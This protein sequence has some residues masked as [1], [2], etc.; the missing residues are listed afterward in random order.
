MRRVDLRLRLQRRS[1]RLQHRQ[2]RRGHCQRSCG[3]ARA[4]CLVDRLPSQ[5]QRQVTAV[6][7]HPISGARC[8]NSLREIHLL[9]SCADCPGSPAPALSLKLA[10]SHTCEF[11]SQLRA[12]LLLRA[13]RTSE[14][15]ESEAPK[16]MIC[17]SVSAICILLMKVHTMCCN[18]H[19]ADG[20]HTRF[21][22]GDAFR[23]CFWNALMARSIGADQA[24]EV[25]FLISDYAFS[26]FDMRS[27]R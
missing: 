5:R 11:V 16:R 6:R 15:D 1:I 4:G 26:T 13:P 7:T 23:H 3:G 12:F 19:P 24:K 25:R 27:R 8:N 18:L 10:R 17:E 20:H 14:A 9:R 22:A 21:A 2:G